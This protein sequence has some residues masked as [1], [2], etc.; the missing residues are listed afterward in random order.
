MADTYNKKEREKR[1]NRKKKEKALRKEMRKEAPKQTEAIIYVDYDGNF[2]ENKPANFEREE[3][4]EL[5]PSEIQTSVPKSE[6]NSRKEGTMK[7]FNSEKKFGFIKCGGKIG[8]IYFSAKDDS[9]VFAENDKVEFD[10]GQG[11]KGPYAFN[12]TKVE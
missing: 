1:R 6:K 5:D 2:T 12:V 11:D 8:E 4:H 9:E 7:F 3:D 10:I